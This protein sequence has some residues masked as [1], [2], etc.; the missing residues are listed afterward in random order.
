MA[1]LASRDIAVHEIE[2]TAE[3]AIVERGAVRRSAAAADER[4]VRTTAKLGDKAADRRDWWSIQC[5]DGHSD[6]VQHANFQLLQRPLA[7]VLQPGTFHK[8]CKLLYLGHHCGSLVSI[9]AGVPRRNAGGKPP[10][11]RQGLSGGGQS[12][13]ADWFVADRHSLSRLP[14]M[15]YQR[16]SVETV[17]KETRAAMS[18]LKQ[19]D[20]S[21][22]SAGRTDAIVTPSGQ[23]ACAGRRAAKFAA[24]RLRLHRVRG[25]ARYR[26]RKGCPPTAFAD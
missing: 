8:A 6:R 11:W 3:S 14:A 2:V 22:S 23:L 21:R 12:L 16:N 20:Q 19:N 24:V 13:R 15:Q 9:P 25:F 26:P 1:R 17:A 18:A 10:P 5:P 4:G 7:Q